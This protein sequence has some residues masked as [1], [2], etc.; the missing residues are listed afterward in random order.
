MS[1]TCPNTLIPLYYLYEVSWESADIVM[2][3]INCE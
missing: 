1:I 2:Y 3:A